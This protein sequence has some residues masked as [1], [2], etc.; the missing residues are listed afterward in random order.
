MPS[1][2]LLQAQSSCHDLRNRTQKSKTKKGNIHSR[3][4]RARK[5]KR[6]NCEQNSKRKTVQKADL[7]GTD[8]AE[9]LCQASLNRIAAHL[10]GGCKDRSG[11][12]QP[13]PFVLHIVSFFVIA[14]SL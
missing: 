12:P 4:R 5:K 10:T 2:A 6:K 7:R 1:A 11:N 13:G 8:R 9:L 14:A 3:H